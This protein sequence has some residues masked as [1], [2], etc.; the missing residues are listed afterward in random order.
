M[1]L[2]ISLINQSLGTNNSLKYIPKQSEHYLVKWSAWQS[3]SVLGLVG[4]FSNTI[5][6][7]TFYSEQNMATSVNAMICM[8]SAYRLVYATTIMHWRNYNMVNYKTLFSNWFSKEKVQVCK[9]LSLSLF[10]C[11]F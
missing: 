6:I 3:L 1:L 4:I 11:S 2:I 10:Y 9:I 8:E 5:L 7:Y